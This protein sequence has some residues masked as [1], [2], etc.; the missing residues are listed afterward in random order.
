MKVMLIIWIA[1]LTIAWMVAGRSFE[2]ALLAAEV[3]FFGFILGFIA[4][5]V[6]EKLQNARIHRSGVYKARR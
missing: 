4:G 6:C 1:A 5:V 3:I 2:Q